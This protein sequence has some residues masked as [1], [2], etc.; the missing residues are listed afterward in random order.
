MRQRRDLADGV[1]G[2]RHRWRRQPDVALFP[3]DK[4]FLIAGPC[5]LE[6][7]DLNRRVADRLAA[8]AHLVPGGVIFKASFDK[9]NRS[10]AAAER[11]PG[12][13]AGLKALTKVR[14]AT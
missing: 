4:L 5:V 14:Y 12:M 10:N 2:A 8:L 7:D 3:P 1:A 6:S 13:D 11:G 9:A